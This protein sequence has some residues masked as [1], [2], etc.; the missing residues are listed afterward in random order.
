MDKET[1]AA[2]GGIQQNPLLRY[3]GFSQAATR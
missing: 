2:F 3:R 1:L